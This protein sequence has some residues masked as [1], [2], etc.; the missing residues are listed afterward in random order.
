MREMRGEKRMN[1]A[2]KERISALLDGE[3][4][5]F[6]TRRVIEEIKD[7]PRLRQYWSSLVTVREGFKEE[8]LSFIKSDISKD[9]ANELGY[10]THPEEKISK[11][12]STWSR[13]KSS[14]VAASGIITVM[15]VLAFNMQNTILVDAIAEDSFSTQASQRIAQAIESPEAINLLNTAV[16]GIDAKLEGLDSSSLGMIQANYVVPSSGNK[17]KVNLSPISSSYDISANQPSKL[18]YL[19]TNKGLFVLSISGDIDSKQKAKILRN[20]TVSFNKNK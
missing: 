4:S 15:V 8:S 1:K 10:K 2:I 18:V 19:R 12:K 6:E 14:Y 9:I 11:D 5:E 16:Q 20:A 17:F 7:D 13:T 3:L